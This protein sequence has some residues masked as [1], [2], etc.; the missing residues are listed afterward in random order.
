MILFSIFKIP[1]TLCLPLVC[2]NSVLVSHE[3]GK[4]V[5]SQE[6]LKTMTYAKLEGGGGGNRVYYGRFENS[7]CLF[8]SIAFQSRQ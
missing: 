1:K 6:H 7:E 4:T 3:F 2:S 8:S 5:Y